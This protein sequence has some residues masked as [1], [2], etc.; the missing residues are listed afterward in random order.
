LELSSPD[1]AAVVEPFLLLVFIYPPLSLSLAVVFLSLRKEF[2][3]SNNKKEQN[4][5]NNNKRK[6]KSKSWP[7]AVPRLCHNNSI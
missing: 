3:K 1:V 7:L 2:Q 6:E 5:N 4:N